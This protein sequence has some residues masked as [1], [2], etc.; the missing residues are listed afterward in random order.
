MGYQRLF[1]ARSLANLINLA[2]IGTWSPR[3]SFQ[4]NG[5][6]EV[7]VTYAKG[8]YWNLGK[9]WAL[10]RVDYGN[11]TLFISKRLCPYQWATNYD[12]NRRLFG[13]VRGR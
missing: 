7:E 10:V 1:S 4:E 12:W 11:L 9:E 13:R 6:L 3:F 8:D 5:D 2:E